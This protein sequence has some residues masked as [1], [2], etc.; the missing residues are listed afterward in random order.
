MKITCSMGMES[1]TGHA[2][3]MMF[4]I[5]NLIG[6]IIVANSF[7]YS[8]IISYYKENSTLFLM[9][10]YYGK[11]H[12]L[13]MSRTAFHTWNIRWCQGIFKWFRGN[14]LYLPENWATDAN[15]AIFVR[16]CLLEVLHVET[17]DGVPQKIWWNLHTLL[18]KGMQISVKW[19]RW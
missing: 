12:L 9:G 16:P 19:Y 5:V 7:P 8:A 4:P 17:F 6:I 2:W 11:H 13:R 14:K 3:E 1:H 18:R 10:I 15:E